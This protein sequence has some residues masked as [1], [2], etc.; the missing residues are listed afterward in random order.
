MPVTWLSISHIWNAS[1]AVPCQA[2][3]AS[4]KARW[5][6]EYHCSY[7]ICDDCVT[8]WSQP[9]RW[10]WGA[11][12]PV[13]LTIPMKRGA[14]VNRINTRI[15]WKPAAVFHLDELVHLTLFGNHRFLENWWRMV[16]PWEPW[17][18]CSEPVWWFYDCGPACLLGA[19]IFIPA[20]ASCLDI[21]QL[22]PTDPIY[23]R[24]CF[25]RVNW[26]V[27]QGAE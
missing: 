15:P 9:F 10:Y 6:C 7:S 4:L 12:W 13:M 1:D 5:S 16:T 14:Q 25:V 21:A 19:F 18:T 23:G 22:S 3:E 11:K 26:K 20:T 8:C 17:G 27:V 24:P 2:F